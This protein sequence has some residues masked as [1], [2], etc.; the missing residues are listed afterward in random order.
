MDKDTSEIA[1]LTE[2]ISKDPKSKLFVP[3]AEEYKKAGDFEMS[4][5]VLTEGLK[6]NPGYASARSLLGK[7]LFEKGD[8][9]GAQKELEEVVK[10]IPDN[11][12]AQ[13]KLGDIYILLGKAADALTHF[14][15]ALS[16]NPK[17]QEIA[18]LVSDI[19]AGRDVKTRI[20]AP[21]PQAPEEAPK[22]QAS[23]QAAAP[24]AGVKAPTPV[25]PAQP[26]GLASPAMAAEEIEEAEEVLVVEPLEATESIDLEQALGSE[27]LGFSA[28]SA[29]E[30]VPRAPEEEVPVSFETPE[31]FGEAPMSGEPGLA[32]SLAF[33]SPEPGETEPPAY[34]GTGLEESLVFPGGEP[35]EAE[36]P[37]SG[38]MEKAADDFNTDTLAELYI[39]QGFYE[40]AVDIYERMLVDNP[41]SQGLKDKLASVRSMA[42]QAAPAAEQKREEIEPFAMPESLSSE[43]GPIE[44]LAQAGG[45]ISEEISAFA[46]P[47][48][49]IEFSEPAS[50]LSVPTVPEEAGAPFGEPVQQP[51]SPTAAFEPKEY[52]PP[53][54][55]PVKGPEPRMVETLAENAEKVSSEPRKSAGSGRKETIDRLENWLHHIM[56][57][58]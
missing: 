34:G 20:H 12:M 46:P 48:E 56:K 25:P 23:A 42:A 31:P 14:K 52:V 33:P 35:G 47:P 50:E 57:E 29:E 32:E 7:L 13:R 3:L 36:L 16:L 51:E 37:A 27:N 5:R 6:H 8:L 2:R 1:E 44:T 9:A 21:K 53:D 11:L 40:K 55:V 54:A 18:S 49:G 45:F 4:I 30:S 43:S 39:S 17:E 10:A 28:E 15:T 24:Q 22:K 26:A 58:K 41:N 19:E 38:E